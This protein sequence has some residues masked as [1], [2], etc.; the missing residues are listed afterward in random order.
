MK[1]GFFLL[2]IAV[3]FKALS[4]ELKYQTLSS[5]YKTKK[6]LKIQKKCAELTS[7]IAESNLS[8]VDTSDN[9]LMTSYK[10]GKDI[11]FAILGNTSVKF[12]S[13]SNLRGPSI[14]KLQP[15]HRWSDQNEKIEIILIPF[16]NKYIALSPDKYEKSYKNKHPKLIEI[17]E[18]TDAQLKKL[19]TDEK[20]KYENEF[21][22][23]RHDTFD[24][25]GSVVSQMLYSLISKNVK[26]LNIKYAEF[27]RKQRVQR[28]TLF[29][30][31]TLARSLLATCTKAYPDENKLS[32]EINKEIKI[33]SESVK[34]IEMIEAVKNRV[35]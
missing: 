30:N 25:Q 21:P 31:L 12:L 35:D 27:K 14:L 32:Q 29:S 24:Y 5:S 15:F 23:E 11:G 2:L 16:D 22:L 13:F 1:A 18:L 28:S 6:Y 8:I 33:L 20:E 3:S 9:I 26:D 19:K 34:E 7:T 17:E 4:I 10:N